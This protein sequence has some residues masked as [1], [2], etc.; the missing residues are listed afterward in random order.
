MKKIN[1]LVL[2]VLIFIGVRS[3]AQEGS[4]FIVKTN[5]I[6]CEVFVDGAK[7]GAGELVKVP[8]DPKK[9]LRQIKVTRPGYLPEYEV[10]YFKEKEI[11]IYVNH[12]ILINEF[13]FFPI[14]LKFANGNEIFTDH[15]FYDYEKYRKSEPAI[16]DDKCYS[17]TEIAGYGEHADKNLSLALGSIGYIDTSYTFLKS[18]KHVCLVEVTLMNARA[19]FFE[20]DLSC[21][22]MA[23]QLEVQL[24]YNFIDKFGKKIYKEEVSA[25]SGIFSLDGL[26]WS[27]LEYDK[28]REF[29]DKLMQETIVVSFYNLMEDKASAIIFKDDEPLNASK[30][31]ILKLNSTIPVSDMKSAL[32]A[33]VTI[34]NNVAF[35]SGCAVSNDGCILTSYHVIADEPDSAIKVITNKGDT[36]NCKV[37]RTSKLA[38][39]AILS[40]NSTFPFSF[41]LLDDVNFEITDAVLAIGTPASMELSQTVSKGIIS[42]IRK[43]ND[44]LTLIQT[45][46]SVSPGNSGGPLLKLPGIFIGVVNSKISGGRID[47]LAFCTPVSDVIT[48]LNLNVK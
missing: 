17:A 46:V 41:S 40:T 18:G 20:V 13:D 3:N 10:F 9:I 11:K 38:D 8:V 35:G 42:G 25:K 36:L 7:V 19:S 28:K 23:M 33:T 37:E 14:G 21:T 16:L 4:D 1:L 2:L 45:D 26:K 24:N 31:N 39:L 32:N 15:Y 5:S 22:N 29:I 30:L 43:S 44:G 48:F 34:K 6:D 12:K 47:G 27:V